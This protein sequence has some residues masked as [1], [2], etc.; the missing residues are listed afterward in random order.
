M[1]LLSFRVIVWVEQCNLCVLV[2]RIHEELAFK[3][4][5]FA[6]FQNLEH[7]SD[8]IAMLGLSDLHDDFVGG[9]ASVLGQGVHNPTLVR[10][11]S[12]GEAEGG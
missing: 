5:H 7:G 8:C 1:S 2:H 12:R 10:L 6:V 3:C 4:N 11:S 9:L